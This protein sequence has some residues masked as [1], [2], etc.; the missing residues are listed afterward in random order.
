MATTTSS[1]EFVERLRDSGICAEGQLEHFL[2]K[3]SGEDPPETIA[4]D[5]VRKGLLTDY[6]TKKILNDQARELLIAG[7]YRVL[8]LLGRGGMG[9]VYLCEHLRMRRLVAIKLMPRGRE[10]D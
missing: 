10:S 2:R 4:T 5:L 1:A 9:S 8:Q 6:Q 7:K 3:G